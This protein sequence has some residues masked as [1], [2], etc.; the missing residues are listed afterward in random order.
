MLVS[1][2]NL[3]GLDYCFQRMIIGNVIVSIH[4]FYNPANATEPRV[5]TDVIRTEQIIRQNATISATS[6]NEL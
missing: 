1:N 2:L 5:Y 4:M 3:E 6:K